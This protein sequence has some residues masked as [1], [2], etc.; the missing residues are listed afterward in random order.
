MSDTQPQFD[1]SAYLQRVEKFFAADSPLTKADQYGGRAYEQ[2]PEQR[3][4]AMEVAL[5]LCQRQ[6]LCAEAPTGIGKSFAYLI[7]AIYRATRIGKPIVITT[8]TIALQEQLLERDIPVLQQLVDV[9]FTAALAKG[10]ENYLCAWRLGNAMRNQ[11]EYLPSD[12]FEPEIQRLARWAQT[13]RDGSRSDLDFVP[14]PQTW[15]LICS[16]AGRCPHDSDQ[17]DSICF[18]KRARKK[19]YKADIIVANHALFCVNLAARQRSNGLQGVLPEY[20]SV[21]VDEAHSFEAAAT[22]HLGLRFSTQ[23]MIAILNRLFNPSANRGLLTVPEADA[24]KRAVT[25]ARNALDRFT[26]Q[27]R[28]WVS[29]QDADPLAYTTP[30]HIPCTISPSWTHLEA[31]LQLIAAPSSAVADAY[32]IE[33]DNLR[34]RVRGMRENLE[35]FLA[36][37]LTETVYWFESAGAGGRNIV[38]NA[39]PL[40]VKATLRPLLFQQPIPVVFTSATLAYNNQIS[41]FTHR[42]GAEEARTIILPSPFDFKNQVDLYVPFSKM[43]DPRDEENFLPV[44]CDQIKEFVIKS[45]GKA[46]VLFTN[47]SFMNRVHDHLEP[48][49]RQNEIRLLVQGK[50]LNRTQLLNEFR[51]DVDSVLFGTDSF[52][53]GVDVPGEALSNVI[54]VKLPF[55]VPS[56]PL[57]AARKEHI[58]RSGGSSFRDYFLPEAV[59]KFR[60]G[61]GRLIRAKS[62]HGM[63]VIL[64]PRVVSTQYGHLFLSAIPD[65]RKH[66]F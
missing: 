3:Q 38:F 21:I 45:H 53:T 63:I 12:A 4:L 19:L 33:I 46:F 36:M 27:L 43:P 1:E 42:V 44:V 6:H 8:H 25:A 56:H 14:S 40:D 17:N 2:R 34:T 57:I 55:A 16:E 58:E 18:L 9:P 28:D 52:W 7:P 41:Y 48:F 65:C 13:T 24:A 31:E 51:S 47:Y 64:D 62:D 39:A 37:K 5:S 59:L 61:I 54:I 29:Q 60:Q 66:I 15:S 35:L 23:G 11:K 30:G 22:T 20:D 49:F 50:E 26:A 32:R 10:R